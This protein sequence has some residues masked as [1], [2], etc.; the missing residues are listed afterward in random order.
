ML[1]IY[2][3]PFSVK[4]LPLEVLFIKPHFIK[5]GSYTSER[6]VTSS[7]IDAA[8]VDNPTGPPLKLNIMHLRISLSIFSK[9]L[10]SIPSNV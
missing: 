9:P 3:R 6:V 5:Y 10:S 2:F 8:R 7:E 1:S 4:T